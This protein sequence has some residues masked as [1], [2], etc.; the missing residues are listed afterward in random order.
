MC[1]YEVRERTLLGKK[2][3]EQIIK[4]IKYIK[5]HLVTVQSQQKSYT[6]KRHCPLEFKVGSHA[7]LKAKPNFGITRF[8]SKGKLALRFIG[9]FEILERFGNVSYRLALPPQL[10]NVHDVFHVSMLRHYIHDPS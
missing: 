3:V 8:G 7:F 10:K 1:W 2:L 9:P 5:Y 4:N 6:D